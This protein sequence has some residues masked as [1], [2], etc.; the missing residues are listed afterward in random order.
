VTELRTE[1]LTLTPPTADDADFV[2]EL[3]NDPGWIKNIGDRGVRT[4]DDDCCQLS[5]SYGESPIGDSAASPSAVLR[6]TE[7][8]SPGAAAGASSWPPSSTSRKGLRPIASWTSCAKSSDESCSSR[9][10]C[11]RRGVTV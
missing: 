6:S 2:L 11:C 4:L 7:M 3:L 9:T 1:R 10:A 8:P 5:R